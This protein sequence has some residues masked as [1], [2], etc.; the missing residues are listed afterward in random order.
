MLVNRKK[1]D[2]TSKFQFD[3]ERTCTIKRVLANY[4]FLGSKERNLQFTIFCFTISFF[5]GIQLYVAP[6]VD[7]MIYKQANISLRFF[8]FPFWFPRSRKNKY[9]QSCGRN[10]PLK[11]VSRPGLTTGEKGGFRFVLN[12]IDRSFVRLIFP[13]LRS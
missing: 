4:V 7:Y 10:E 8:L 2:S 11:P 3:L 6:I 12:V 9:V 5:L 13:F 1:K